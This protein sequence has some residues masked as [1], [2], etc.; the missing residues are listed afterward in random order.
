MRIIGLT[1]GIASGKSAVAEIIRSHGIPVIDADQLARDAVVPGSAA[2]DRIV[3]AYGAGVLHADGS[4]DRG[5]L[6]GKIFSNAAARKTLE[7]ILHPAIK[8]LAEK[9]LDVLRQ[10]AVPAVFYMAPL[11]IE[12]G[13][14]DRVDEIWVVSVDRE[15]Q[16]LRLQQRDALS[17]D[18]AEKRLAAQ[19]PMAEK[20]A[21]GR[22]VIDNC[23]SMDELH[24]RVTAV[25][26]A[27]GLVIS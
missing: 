23:G 24:R 5:A 10:E 15:T 19:M 26:T 12:A 18:E 17:L 21:Y 1:G 27:E 20:A 11:L 4:L 25:L 2:L 13:A 8:E 9:R 22:I 16:L 14:T 3:A 7:S 6:A